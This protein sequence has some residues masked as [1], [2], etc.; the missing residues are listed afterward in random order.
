MAGAVVTGASPLSIRGGGSEPLPLPQ[1]D[2]HARLPGDERSRE[3]RKR[4]GGATLASAVEI[5][6]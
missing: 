5:A 6:F 3:R 1:A 4:A 2:C